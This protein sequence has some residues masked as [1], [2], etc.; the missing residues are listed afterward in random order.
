MTPESR[1]STSIIMC[2]TEKAST[3]EFPCTR[4]R[5]GSRSN[6]LC[7]PRMDQ[8]HFRPRR[9]F[10]EHRNLRGGDAARFQRGMKHI[11]TSVAVKRCASA[12]GATRS[13]VLS[14]LLLALALPNS[15]C[16]KSNNPPG[17]PKPKIALVMKSLANEFFSTMADGAKKH[18]AAHPQTYE[19]I[20]NGIKNETDL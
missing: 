12:E 19:L 9:F 15:G 5:A 6:M 3:P 2:S 20:V 13:A 10:R 17:K 14:A 7:A 4:S 8:R 1:I 11:A 16:N 18:Q